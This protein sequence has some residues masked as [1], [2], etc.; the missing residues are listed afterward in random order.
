MSRGTGYR[1][2]SRPSLT[3]AAMS[4]PR[5]IT[6]TH[7]LKDHSDE[8]EARLSWGYRVTE[9]LYEGDS[10]FQHVEVAVGPQYGRMLFLD[11]AMMTTEV[12]EFVYH[13][14]L[15]HVP[16]MIARGHGSVRRVL[17][18]GG[19]DG[20]LAREV[21]KH[22]DVEHVDMVEIDGKVVEVAQ[23]FLPTIG[24]AVD[25]PRLHVH[26][27]DGN[28]FVHALQPDSYDVVLIDSADPV[29]PGIV[30]FQP[31]FYQAVKDALR[32]HGVVA[33][34]GM[35][36]WLQ[37]DGQRFMFANLGRVFPA[38]HAYVAT[39]PTYPGGQWTFALCAHEPLDPTAFDADAARQTTPGA[40]YYTPE[41]HRGAFALPPFVREN[42]V[43]VAASTQG[44]GA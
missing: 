31:P 8:G 4:D 12:D 7:P 39:I 5:W 18:I 34:Q 21:L 43:D 11:G 19:G 2:R 33:A 41:V 38:V 36:P 42:T 22:P 44:G 24:A 32:P 13:E 23:R 1:T 40:R 17:I 29:G 27:E 15:S 6:E 3:E 35:S 16:C 25:D 9:S 37:R 14:M 10:D 26:T 28:A 30:L 20:G